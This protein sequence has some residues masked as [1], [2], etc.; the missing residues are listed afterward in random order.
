ME[1]LSRILVSSDGARI[2]L[3]TWRVVVVAG[4]DRGV[5]LDLGGRVAVIGRSQTARLSLTDTTV[6]REHARIEP[7]GTGYKIVDLGSKSG[8]RLGGVLVEAAKLEPGQRLELGDTTLLVEASEQD[9]PAPR[10]EGEEFEGMI[11]ASPAMRDLFGLVARVALLDLPVLLHGETGT[12]KEVLARALHKRSQVADGP[13][14]VVDGTLLTDPTHAR[15]ELF[16]HQKGAFT[17]AERDRD[18]AFVAADGGTLFLDEVAELPLDVQAQL[19]RVLQEGEIKPLGSDRSRS[20]KV[21]LVSATHRDLGARVAENRF[22]ADLFFRLAGVTLEI[23]PLRQRPGDIERM[24][25][26]WLPSGLR[27]EAEAWRR[28]EAH[29][30]PGNVRELR[31]VLTRALAMARD[32]LVRASDLGLEAPVA[33][34]APSDASLGRV[35][36]VAAGAAAPVPPESP[37]TADDLAPSSAKRKAKM[38]AD[39]IRRAL[40]Q[41]G[42]NRDQAA[43]LLGISRATLFRR[44]RDL[45]EE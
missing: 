12:G 9:L 3:K 13:L 6:S 23:P 14:V 31:F 1:T 10:N 25:R 16:G 37:I 21:R 28:L 27:L 2:H 22:R 43:K 11:G 19:L 36:M 7:E 38:E 26:R 45:K 17:G 5:E 39:A 44:L 41:T 30:W 32:G 34:P 20:V 15:S 8:I 18:G 29:P 40:R 24:V 42:G 4:P 33:A 35:S